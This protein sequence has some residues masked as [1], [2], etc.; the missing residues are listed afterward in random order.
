MPLRSRCLHTTLLV[1][2]A[3]A[4]AGSGLAGAPAFAS[5][6]SAARIVLQKGRHYMPTDLYLRRGDTI[7]LRNG[8]ESLIHH[9]FIETDRFS[10]D[11]GDQEPGTETHLTLAEPGDFVIQ[12]GIHPKMKL[13]IH[14]Q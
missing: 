4:L 6:S 14:V 3:L 2:G 8:D 10:F 1:V 9:A 12:C 7:T 11:A 13:T 5:L